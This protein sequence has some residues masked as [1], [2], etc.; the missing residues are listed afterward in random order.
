[1]LE[2]GDLRSASVQSVSFTNN[3]NIPSVFKQELNAGE[4]GWHVL[5]LQVSA[6]MGRKVKDQK[7]S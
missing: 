4:G 5:I 7:E 1:M 2:G 6:P 3:V